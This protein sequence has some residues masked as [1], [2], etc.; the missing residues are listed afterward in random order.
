MTSHFLSFKELDPEEK[1]EY[2][3]YEDS[4]AVPSDVAL[5]RIDATLMSSLHIASVKEESG[6][7]IKGVGDPVYTETEGYP[8]QKTDEGK[9][10][11]DQVQK[12]LSELQE[13][14]FLKE[15]AIKW[16]G[17]DPME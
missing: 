12:V 14:G 17:F 10:L 4:R 7:K 3:T 16:F 8:F 15:T 2:V 5:G 9:E 6:L 13:E 1:I 11:R